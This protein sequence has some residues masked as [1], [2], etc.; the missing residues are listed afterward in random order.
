MGLTLWAV[1]GCQN[2]EPEVEVRVCGD[3]DVPREIDTL[4]VSLLG[5]DR[6]PRREAV[7]ELLE[8]PEA[9]VHRLP[10]SISFRPFDGRAWAVV[11]GLRDGRPELR[12]ERRLDLNG[13][14][15]T[16]VRLAANR[17]CLGVSCP[18]GQ[19]CIGGECELAP[20]SGSPPSSCESA[21]SDGTISD[22]G[23]EMD[24][25][26][27]PP[28]DAETEADGAS[29]GDVGGGGDTG[30]APDAASQ[31]FQPLCPGA[32]TGTEGDAPRV[33]SD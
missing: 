16:S 33:D 7:L 27:A 22:T 6:E 23:A 21:E 28:A 24:G 32:D 1:A 20:R 18:E 26:G 19:T 13:D 30:T 25:S 14:T 4:R 31:P 15:S 2:P 10:Q 8:C 5:S 11:K 12:F 3:V 29:V 9:E 17:D